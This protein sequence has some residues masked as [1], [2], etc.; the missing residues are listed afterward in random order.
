MYLTCITSHSRD[1]VSLELRQDLDGLEKGVHELTKTKEAITIGRKNR[2]VME[3]KR[4]DTKRQ[5]IE[6]SEKLK[7][8]IRERD[9]TKREGGGACFSA[10]WGTAIHG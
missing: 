7:E 8:L 3:R 5:Q 6:S 2:A 9:N 4:F 1:K 10:T